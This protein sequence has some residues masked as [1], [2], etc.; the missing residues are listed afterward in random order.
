MSRG[1]FIYAD[2]AATTQLTPETLDT[3]LPF[4]KDEFANPSSLYSFSRT[5]KEALKSSRVIIAE[6]IG[7][8]PEEIF[9][10]SGG[11][12]RDNWALKE[13]LCQRLLYSSVEHH[14]VLNSCTTL[15]KSG[16][17]VIKLPVNKY[18]QVEP[19]VLSGYVRRGDLVTIMTAN[20]E[21]GSINDIFSLVLITKDIGAIFHTD[22]VQAV[23]H[24]PIDVH[25][26]NVD[27]L[28]ASAHKFNG[29]KGIGFL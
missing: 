23:G 3:M 16:R 19:E 25:T 4:L 15:K 26:W 8:S 18:G 6:C 11:T 12:E 22:A 13:T 2:N 24:I 27:M 21:I 5:A 28:S 29:P 14:A 10:T 20:N 7:A 9:F 1:K 17:K